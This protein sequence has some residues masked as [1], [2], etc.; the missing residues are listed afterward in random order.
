[1]KNLTIGMR[2][3]LGFGGLMLM[4][5]FIL[6][7]A[8]YTLANQNSNADFT[9]NATYP[10]VA[11]VQDT[12]FLALDTNRQT[13]NII[14]NTDEKKLIRYK[15]TLEKDY[16][17]I[18]ENIG[19]LERLISTDKERELVNKIKAARADFIA[20]TNEV[21]PPAM[22]N[23]KEGAVKALYSEKYKTQA[24]YFDALKQMV[25]LQE[26]T[27]KEGGEHTK[28]VYHNGMVM[29][30]I[31]GLLSVVSGTVV[32]WMITRKL[33]T[34]LGGEPGY[35]MAI[36]EK[37]AEGDLSVAIDLHQRDNTSLLFSM[38]SMRDKL[39][40]IVGDV[41]E[42]TEAITT[43]SGQIAS[44]NQDLSART[45]SQA[46][47]LEETAASME[48]LTSTVKQNAENARQ[49]N[50]MAASASDI[51]EKGGDVV[52]RVVATMSSINDSSK[53][54]VDIISVIDGI[55]FQTNI[56]A[57]NAAVEAARAGE[58]GRGFAVV[59]SEVRNLAQRS[60]AAAKEIKELIGDSVD[61]VETGSRQVDVAGTTMNEVVKSIRQVTDIMGE[62]TSASQEQ[63]QGID[64]INTVIV[65]MDNTTQKNAALVEEAAAAS[66]A[67]S[68]QSNTL[69]RVVNT[70]KLN[71]SQRTVEN[72]ASGRV[73]SPAKVAPIKS[74]G[75]PQVAA[76]KSNPTMIRH[77]EK[78]TQNEDGWEEF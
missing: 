32:A 77:E 45:E 38:R 41:R 52:S 39:A 12:S 35:A 10:K 3:A 26:V 8:F 55:A 1:M 68:D 2:L 63:S 60:A 17:K 25:D 24:A 74:A 72:R 30:S 70:F 16:A 66:K 28:V 14:I 23:D 78:K 46:S 18:D 53:K 6:I 37:I 48:Q 62:I 29:M 9:I 75:K 73:D 76:K 15:E 44:G 67:L 57:L 43:A 42:G 51:A 64:Q 20:Y 65:E 31:L 59:A 54:I 49:A 21:I 36:S 11:L 34:Q 47:S 61:K 13:R 7:I 71:D 19:K 56:L 33:L 5:V 69:M 58:Q 4:M 40:R 50:Q 22:K 27:M